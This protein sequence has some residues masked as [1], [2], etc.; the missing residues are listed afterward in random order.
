MPLIPCWGNH[1][2]I[3]DG[4]TAT[5]WA[6]WESCNGHAITLSSWIRAML[7]HRARLIWCPPLDKRW[8]ALPQRSQPERLRVPISLSGFLHMM[9]SPFMPPLP[10][11]CLRCGQN[12]SLRSTARLCLQV[13][14]PVLQSIEARASFSPLH[15]CGILGIC[16]VS[17]MRLQVLIVVNLIHSIGWEVHFTYIGSLFVAVQEQVA[18]C[19]W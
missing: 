18:S 10:E 1:L 19:L 12:P 14:L 5:Q 6:S 3:Y 11:I 4:G 16:Q 17:P 9:V 2:P 15:A 8:W 7:V 13:S